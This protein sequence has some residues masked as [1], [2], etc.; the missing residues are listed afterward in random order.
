MTVL[1]SPT[2]IIALTAALLMTLSGTA[3]FD[4]TKYPDWSG[5]WKRAPGTVN[6]WD[7]TKRP[8]LGPVD[9]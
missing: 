9:I 1:R 5:Q 6:S 4:E 7:E 3:A 2:G 8:G